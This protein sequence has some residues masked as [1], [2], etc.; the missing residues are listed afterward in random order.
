MLSPRIIIHGQHKNARDPIKT[1]EV[2]ISKINRIHHIMC[3]EALKKQQCD[4]Q[5]VGGEGMC[6]LIF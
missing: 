1:G 4:Y 2:I 5:R 3:N 6:A